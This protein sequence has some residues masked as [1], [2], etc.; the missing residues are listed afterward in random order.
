LAP[1]IRIGTELHDVVDQAIEA[2]RADDD[3][4]QR[5]GCLVHVVRATSA[6][7]D[8]DASVVADTP[9]IRRMAIPTLRERLTRVAHWE[10]YDKRSEEWV[11]VIPNDPI[12]HATT[13]RGMWDGLR[14]IVGII[15]AP[16]LR[17]DGTIITTPG[18]DAQTGFLYVPNAEFPP[19]PLEPTQ[20]DAQR[21][22]EALRECFCDFPYRSEEHRSTTIAALLTLVARP[23]IRGSVPA[24]LFDAATRGSG[25]T[26]QGDGISL[27]ATGRTSAKMNYPADDTELEK[28]LGSYAI[29]A[30]AL[31][32]FDNVTRQFGGGPLDRCLTAEDTVELR[33][34]GKSEIPTLRWRSTII[35]TGN[36]IT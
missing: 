19:V 26:L 12:V 6:E 29:R 17:P 3:L 34:L 10:R 8:T 11:R 9:Q 1:S 30:P 16:A 36:N 13:N 33:I 27:I 23:A 22:L 5:D 14:P 32:N 2:L 31:V 28:V 4:Y 25:K 21:A 15:E 35:A 7:A 20:E 18:Y 24:F